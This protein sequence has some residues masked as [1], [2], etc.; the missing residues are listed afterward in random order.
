VSEYECAERPPSSHVVIVN[1]VPDDASE[2][3]AA[4]PTAKREI[5]IAMRTRGL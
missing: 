2:A 3:G 5:S 4:S 1:F